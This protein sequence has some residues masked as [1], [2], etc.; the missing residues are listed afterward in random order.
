MGRAGQIVRVSDFE[1]GIFP[2]LSRA[3]RKLLKGFLIGAGVIVALAAVGVV[4]INLYVQSAGTQ[5]RIED[6]LSSGLKAPVHLTSTI[7]TP[8]S[9]LKASGI[10]V[11]QTPP[12]AGNF[13]EA[14]GFTAHFSWLA[15][16]KH[17]LDASEVSLDEPHVLWFQSPGGRWELPRQEASVEAAPAAAPKEAASP[18]AG[19]G[20]TPAIATQG[21]PA[22]AVQTTT[23]PPTLTPAPSAKPPG[24]VTQPWVITVHKLAVNGA[25]FDF[26]DDKGIRVLEFAG[27]QF[28]CMNPRAAGTQGTAAC[29]NI[30]LHD[31]VY[32]EE[33]KTN[34]S[35]ASG[36]LNLNSIET[37]VGGGEIRG[38]AQVLTHV[39]RSPF[40]ASVTFD[41]VNVDRLMTEAGE[42]TGEITGTLGGALQIKG[43][44]GKT[45]SLNGSEHLELAGGQM[46]NIEILQL[47]GRGL[48][49]PDLV[50]LKLKTAT[51]DGRV[52]N[53]TVNVDKLLLQSQN[54]EVTG[55][56][57]AEIGGKLALHLRL[58]VNGV[59]SQRVPSFILTYFKEGDTA[60]SRYIDFEVG[61]TLSHPKTDLLENILGH[62]IQSEMT[63]L[64][65]SIF[66]KKQQR[67]EPEGTPP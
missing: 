45:S 60:D 67:A 41:G 66:G 42:P 26:W 50:Q 22:I 54:L 30:S 15:L 49:I 29:K 8:W 13:L 3:V 25:S 28:D 2:Y 14:A 58:T 17:R 33:M 20:A 35:F 43:N 24:P 31:R 18:V 27:V 46:Q 63:D 11:P 23:T 7:V 55:T 16:L 56:G 4:A 47:L 48:Q 9:G 59:I 62:R 10:S 1:F 36:V 61:N 19:P 51:V 37:G 6:A 52:V 53:G 44:S 32:F 64:I 57:T 40:N 39:K 38:D 5:K 65:K 12:A 34:W 21:T